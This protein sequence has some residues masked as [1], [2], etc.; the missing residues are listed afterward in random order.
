MH[1]P[2]TERFLHALSYYRNLSTPM[3]LSN[4]LKRKCIT[5]IPPM[6]IEV[7][8]DIHI[9]SYCIMPDHYHALIKCNDSHDASKYAQLIQDSYTRYFNISHN[10]KGPLWQS[11]FRRKHIVSNAAILHVQRYIHLNPSTDK[12]VERPEH[13]PYSSYSDYIF[14]P[15]VLK[16]HKEIS[17]RNPGALKKFTE[18]NIQ[19]QRRLKT[20]KKLFI[21][22]E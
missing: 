13:W 9:V 5:H 20:I 17:I 11:K 22:N 21:D 1:P 12:L 7:E 14:N 10:R 2:D 15:S 3:S 16:Q 18:S 19:Y 4:A 8:H 6:Q